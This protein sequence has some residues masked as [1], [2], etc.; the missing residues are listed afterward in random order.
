[1]EPLDI[2]TFSAWVEEDGVERGVAAVLEELQRIRQHGFT[3]AELAR[4]K[5]NL[6][7][8]VESVYTQRDQRASANLVQEY[9]GHFLSGAPVPGIEVEW[10]LYQELLPQIALAEFRQ[11]RRILAA[12]RGHGPVGRA[13]RRGRTRAPMGS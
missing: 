10:E 3:D 1:M 11:P 5:T 8:S 4:E 12:D 9:V 6:L 13:T 7:R 2:V